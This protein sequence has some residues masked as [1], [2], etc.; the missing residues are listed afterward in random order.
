MEI[1]LKLIQDKHPDIIEAILK[2]AT[3]EQITAHQPQIVNDLRLEGAAAETGRVQAVKEQLIPGHE[4]LIEGLMFDGKT[5]GEQAAVKVLQAEKQIRAR[6]QADN[7]GDAPAVLPQ[8]VTDDDTAVIDANLPL[9]AQCQAEVI[10][11]LLRPELDGL[12]I[13]LDRVTEV[14]FQLLLCQGLVTDRPWSALPWI[15]A[16]QAPAGTRL[17]LERAEPASLSREGQ[18]VNAPRLAI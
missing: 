14:F 8:P 17:V 5:T 12:A 9:E 1:T 2:A 11:T 16:R 13:I 6:S 18:R 7:A 15:E 4:T 10:E 3:L